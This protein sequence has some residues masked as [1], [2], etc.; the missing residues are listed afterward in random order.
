MTVRIV[1][2]TRPIFPPDGAWNIRDQTGE[3]NEELWPDS[4]IKEAV[5]ARP[6]AYFKA[7]RSANGWEWKSRYKGKLYW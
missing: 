3:I 6:Y 1:K 4:W 7:Q 2:I 5:S